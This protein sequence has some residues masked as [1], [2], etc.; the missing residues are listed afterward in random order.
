[1]QTCPCGNS[2][3]FPQCCEPAILGDTLAAS[4]EALMRS[5]YCAYVLENWR[6]LYKTW[7]PQTRPTRKELSRSEST[8]W[9][10]LE[11]VKTEGGGHQDTHGTVEF[12]AHFRLGS[13]A[14]SLHEVSQ[15][16]KIQGKWLYV[17]GDI[18]AGNTKFP[19]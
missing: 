19:R 7:H 5:R 11:I 1:M 8:Q 10:R 16:E 14:H 6:Y 17:E 12:I 18:L 9:L 2:R 3:P 15:F 13:E 4:A